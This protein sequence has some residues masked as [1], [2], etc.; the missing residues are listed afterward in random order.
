MVRD[1]SRRVC[2]GL[3]ALALLG[4]LAHPVRCAAQDVTIEVA[5]GGRDELTA[6]T[7][8]S[9]IGP[10]RSLARAVALARDIRRSRP[11]ARD[12][13][14]VL[15]A[16]VHTIDT[17]VRLGP[18]DSGTAEKP[19]IIRGS[20]GATVLRGSLVIEP[21]P[22]PVRGYQRL[23][24][25]ARKSAR[26]YRLPDRLAAVRRIDTARPKSV[27]ILIERHAPTTVPSLAFEVF[28]AD[29]VMRPARGPNTGW[30]KVAGPAGD[31]TSGL[32]SDAPRLEA[33]RG[34]PDLWAAGYWHKDYTYERHQVRDVGAQSLN[35]GAL[36]NGA[37]HL[38]TPFAF[39]LRTGA[40]YHVYHALAEL[41]APGE[42]YRDHARNVLIAWPRGNTQRLEISV[43]ESAFVSE[44]A[45]HVRIADL[46]IEKFYGDAVRVVGG[47][48]VVIENSTLRFAGL[49]GASF[50]DAQQSGIATSDI[51]DTGEGGVLLSGGD[52]R[53]L[54]PAGLFVRAC[55]I[56]RFARIQYTFRPAVD[57][58]GVGNIVS[59]SYIADAPNFGIQF[60]GNDHR[61]E[62]N[63]IT[64]VVNDTSDA[65]ALYT[66]G[67]WTARGTLVRHNFLHDL[68]GRAGFDIKGIY[69]D[70]FTSGITV[71]GNLFLR[72]QQPVFIGGGRDNLVEGNVF[73]ASEPAVHID[74]RGLGW[75]SKAVTDTNGDERK[76]LAAV[77]Y[78]QEPWRSRY[79]QLLTLLQDEPGD[80]RR[81]VSRGNVMIES[82]P[83]RFETQ[84]K[85]RNQTL[86]PDFGARGVALPVKP[87]S[88]PALRLAKTAAEAGRLLAIELASANGPLLP[89]AAMDRALLAGRPAKANQGA[90]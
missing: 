42:W 43:A 77:P 60:Q 47:R 87:D 13:V 5:P 76:R 40:R 18:A 26:L 90:P 10:V 29:G 46:T 35:I 74:S 66:S 88:L 72:V 67:D 7:A 59:D 1:R 57:L 44:G 39:D 86:G 51:S 56:E 62:R 12:I 21:E 14:I 58:A 6:S 65:G 24:Q 37:L 9:R 4:I 54:A 79:P 31:G 85:E 83:Y 16:G 27:P 64:N 70:D 8:G 61:I 75:G 84:A 69:L 25:A 49:H 34:E 52:R 53:L 82:Q 55:R 81:N 68:R 17:P 32:L 30:A 38:A 48:D 71:R 50:V 2:A 45:S 15:A 73:V 23:G 20:N 33:W 63:E 80:A 3:A 36:N 89:Y 78:R 41:D 11:A 19:L 22:G 28:D